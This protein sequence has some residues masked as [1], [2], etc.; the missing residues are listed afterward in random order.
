MNETIRLKFL[1]SRGPLYGANESAE[2]YR[3][4]GVRFLRTTDIADNGELVAGGVFIDEGPAK[5]HLLHTGDILLSRS[6]TLGRCFVYNAT[7]HGSCAYAGYLVRFVPTD[8]LNPRFF[9]YL[10]KSTTFLQW[11]EAETISSTIGNVNG[12]KFANMPVPARNR[13]SQDAVADFLEHETAKIDHLIQKKQ[14]LIRLTMDESRSIVNRLITAG[15]SVAGSLVEVVRRMRASLPTDWKLQRLKQ[16]SP[17]IGVGVVVRPSD[18]IAADGVPFIYGGNIREDRIDAVS[19]RRMSLAD[20]NRLGQSRLRGGDVLV[21]R[22]GAPGVA[23]VV[24][25]ELDGANCASVV[26]VRGAPGFNSHWLSAAINSQFVR[27]QVELVQYGAAQEQFNVAH[28]VD[29]WIPVPP[30]P[31]QDRIA[32]EVA[33]IRERY[34]ALSITVQRAIDGLREYRSALITAAVTGQIDV[35]HHAPRVP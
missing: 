26:L 16:I 13:S 19:A 14:V 3:N 24:P 35:R 22:V 21:V 12:Q 23:A 17:K 30:R 9:F 11:L 2:S 28:A 6:G 5:E 18:Y 31:E 4:E 29:F 15:V 32:G 20:S 8:V 33:M 34:D 25:P 10:T 27:W 7:K 1:C